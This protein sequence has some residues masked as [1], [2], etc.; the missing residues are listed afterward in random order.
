VGDRWCIPEAEIAPGNRIDL[1]D[2]CIFT[3]DPPTA[4][5]LDDA[6]HI[7]ELPDSTFEIG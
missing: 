7:T 5:D 2:T 4:R 6:L 1:R 3:I